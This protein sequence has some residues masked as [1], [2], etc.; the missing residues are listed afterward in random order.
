MKNTNLVSVIIPV[1]NAENYI[2]ETVLSVLNQTH[3]EIELIIV[4]DG[5]KDNTLAK[6]NQLKEKK[7]RITIIDKPNSGVC[8]SRNMGTEN[9]T[10]KFITFL[11]ADDVWEPTF[12]EDCLNVFNT[13][14]S[15]KAVYCRVQ[16]I[17]EKSDKLEEFI[18]AKTIESAT[19]VLEWKRDY[20]ASM[21][22]TIYYTEVA[23]KAGKFDPRLSTAADQDFH[24]RVAS[25][26][27]I[28]GLD[29]VLFY[30]RIHENN[31]H[32]NISVM[33]KDHILVFKKAEKMN[34]YP[35]FWF[36]QKCFSKLYLTLAGSWWK[37]GNNKARG[38]YFILRSFFC[39]PP[40]ILK[41]IVK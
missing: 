39:Y 18:E 16:L 28:V 5:S 19:D 12:I 36:K 21:G 3:E 4:N 31:M 24:L 40:T 14:L 6:L 41:R 27:P 15:I 22:C 25:I 11:D 23:K 10:G 17:N 37:N 30:Y 34:L 20:V 2:E 29:R 33:E 8:D 13:D 32:S 38:L 7:S 1:Y 26:T 9:A 35:S